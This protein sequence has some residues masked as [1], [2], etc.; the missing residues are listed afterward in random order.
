M[1]YLF[2]KIL[3]FDKLPLNVI[4]F[5]MTLIVVLSAAYIAWVA[6]L[7]MRSKQWVSQPV[8][9][10][11]FELDT[12]LRGA[13]CNLFKVCYSF[14]FGGVE[15]R[16]GQVLLNSF[17]CKN[18]KT[19]VLEEI[20]NNFDSGTQMVVWVDPKWPKLF[21]LYRKISVCD[22]GLALFVG[23]FAGIPLWLYINFFE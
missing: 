1:T 13:K 17:C 18:M 6:F 19:E 11:S 12:S 14:S 20:R 9:L 22:L 23:F 3:P 8:K 7:N 5:F 21:S 16:G 4:T 2:S 15:Y 10:E